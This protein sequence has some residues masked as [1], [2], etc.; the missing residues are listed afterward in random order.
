MQEKAISSLV[1]NIIILLCFSMIFDFYWTKFRETSRMVMVYATGVMLG[2]IGFLLMVMD[3]K[4]FDYI[5]ID[6]RTVLLSLTGLFFGFKAT[7]TATIVIL[8]LRIFVI[9]GTP[10]IIAVESAYTIYA[11][12][13]GQ[14]LCKINP[15]WR[16]GN[17]PKTLFI[18]AFSTHIVM[19]LCLWLIPTSFNKAE[20]IKDIWWVVLIVFPAATVLLGRLLIEQ[21]KRWNLREQLTI[22][23][24]RFNK[25]AM[26]S[27][28][29]FWE[30]NSIGMI[31][32][33]SNSVETVLGYKKEEIIQ[34]HPKEFIY[35]ISSMQILIE[36]AQSDNENI[37]LFEQTIALKHK[38]QSKV[39]CNAR[40]IKQI[41]A[42]GN[43]VG[44]I[45]IAHN[46]TPIKEMQ[47][48]MELKQTLLEEQ[49]HKIQDINSKLRQNNTQITEQNLKLSE[50]IR[51][52]ANEN[53]TKMGYIAGTSRELKNSIVNINDSLSALLE[54]NLPPASQKKLIHQARYSTRLMMMLANDIMD[55]DRI[56]SGTLTF[57]YNIVNLE[58][59]LNEIYEYYHSQNLYVLK[60]PVA[61]VK[62]IELSEE[63]QIV[64]TDI[65]RLKQILSNLIGNAYNFTKMG[66]IE[67]C[68][69][70]YSKD[71]LL[72]S[73]SDTGNGIPEDVYENVY[74]PNQRR[75]TFFDHKML[76]DTGLGLF[77]SKEL[78]NKMG[79]N[80][81]FNSQSGQG[82]TFYFTLPFTKVSELAVK[83][84]INYDWQ[85]KYALIIGC[86]RYRTVYI[87]EIIS[88]YKIKYKT[89]IIENEEK[90]PKDIQPRPDIIL[91]DEKIENA[92]KNQDIPHTVFSEKINP[93]DFC[94]E[95]NKIL[96]NEKQN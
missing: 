7:A 92:Y 16:S 74:S 73:I 15:K 93:Y 66:K 11:A 77:V 80:I 5:R 70:Q 6:T 83:N 81:W 69:K 25:V 68:C 28:D 40:G 30:I 13:L 58:Q 24:D 22:S 50:Q 26:C 52:T 57:Q 35:D 45:G 84:S 51:K 79:G 23:N 3:L 1:E 75:Q 46:I 94:Q 60:K 17:W 91:I 95:I 14:L 85:N 65:L 49:N 10:E 88:K 76:E 62:K 43:T 82:T 61:F 86:D 72:F 63:N 71:K 42:L 55:L 32:Y 44:Y 19:F 48:T 78:I 36:Y 2:I 89:V 37:K 64:K 38:N 27:D 20:I 8:L 41:N 59:L 54:T 34:H 21:M 96:T 18:L 53:K 31:T 90:F 67:L 4:W 9:G 12:F 39:I 56:E 87:S 29:V 47:E 33:V